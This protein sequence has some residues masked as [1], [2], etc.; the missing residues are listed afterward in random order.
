MRHDRVTF[1]VVHAAA[2]T[3]NS[4][5]SLVATFDGS[6]GLERLARFGDDYVYRLR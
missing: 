2:W 1:I 3:D 6:P 5:A 4:G